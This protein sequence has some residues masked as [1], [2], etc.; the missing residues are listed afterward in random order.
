MVMAGGKTIDIGHYDTFRLFG[1]TFDTNVIASTIFV[2]LIIFGL[3]VWIRRVA[4][5]GVPGKF[6]VLFEMVVFDVVGAVAE[7][8][9]GRE[10]KKYVPLGVTLFLVILISNWSGA[11]PTA[12]HPGSSFDILPP[13]TSD[14]N[15]PLAM[16]FF[17]VVW[18]H[19]EAVRARGIR[20]YF[21]HY[22]KPFWLF[23]PI[24]VIEE[25]VKPITLALRLFG[26]LFAGVIMLL[27]IV[28]LLPV[29]LVPF[30]E[31]PWKLFDNL[32]IGSLQAYIFMI[33][34]MLYFGMATSH[35]EVAT[36][37]SHGPAPEVAVSEIA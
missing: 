25:L 9:I 33:L 23:F 18:V 30:L 13:A 6:Q 29:Y 15:L 8:A 5:D 1:H 32:F 35:D 31:G 10:Y 16:A 26:N 37:S 27:I 2:A 19:I 3:G 7:P 21:A 17:V 11:I 22:F 12:L 28:V 14:I 34:S 20:G 24:N 4:T 36:D